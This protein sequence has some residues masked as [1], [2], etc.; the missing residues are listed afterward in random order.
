MD[1]AE[2]EKAPLIVDIEADARTEAEGIIK[3]A[4]ALIVEKR[5][6]ARRQVESL[7]NEARLKGREQAEAIRKKAMGAGAREV[8]RR[9]MHTKAAIV[10]DVMDRVQK[11]L[12]AMIHEA[13]YRSALVNWIAEAALGLGT[14]SAEV[15]ASEKERALIDDR[16]LSEAGEKVRAATG[17][18]VALTLSAGGPLPNQGIVVTAADGRMAFN[19]QVKT[20]VLRQQRKIHMLIHDALFADTREEQV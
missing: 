11:R 13:E 7:L 6:Y 10:Q 1:P 9:L 4:E 18:P 19:N 20:R 16:M 3:E 17:K 15:N 8:K 2:Q 12:A 5:E 14:E